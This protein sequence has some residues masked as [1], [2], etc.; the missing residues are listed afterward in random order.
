MELQVLPAAVIA[1]AVTV[2]FL[3]V[4]RPVA[5][6][7]RL[8]DRPGGR[9]H[10]SGHV[11][12]IGGIAMY[13]GVLAGMLVIGVVSTLTI[14]IAFSFFL[15]VF[16]GSIDD[17]YGVP[18]LVR[19][20]VQISCVAIM[21]FSA[22]LMLYSLGNPFGLG[23]IQLG[24]FAFLGTLLVSLTVINAYNLVDGVDGL[25]GILALIALIGI[26]LIG[27]AQSAS[28]IMSLITAASIV[29]FLI[30]NFPVIANRPVRTFMGDAGSTVIGFTIFW[31]MLGI[32]Q[33]GEALISPV[34][35]LWFASIP[36][37]D[38]L[39]CFVRRIAA[40]KSPFTPGRDHFH[41]TLRRGGFGV[42][43]KLAILGGLQATYAL[44]GGLGYKFGVPDVALFTAWSVLGLTQ[45]LVI[46][47]VSRR[48]RL[49]LM[50]QLR[51]GK[52]SPYRRAK[53]EALR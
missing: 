22:D 11:P 3:I 33:G 40:G 45:R 39:T 21:V 6:A 32:S 7:S 24:P 36:I 5:L 48:H 1:F 17:A 42:R 35:G 8:V 46:R 37:Y 50:K 41:H 13:L 14:G 44:I 23:E 49:Y 52:L 43:Q 26:A 29:A 28:T 9:K 10:H 30:F 4:L 20:A 27:P 53:A 18:P 38:T 15:L 19:I 16:A 2:A 34:A 12:I 31:A 25:A 47:T 51:A